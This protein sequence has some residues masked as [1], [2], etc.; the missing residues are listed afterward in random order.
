MFSPELLLVRPILA[1]VPGRLPLSILLALPDYVTHDTGTPLFNLPAAI[2]RL[3]GRAGYAR[4][5]KVLSPNIWAPG[6]SDAQL[7]QFATSPFH[8]RPEIF[9]EVHVAGLR[10]L[11][12]AG[13]GGLQRQYDIVHFIGYVTCMRDGSVRLVLSNE[14][15]GELGPGALRDSLVAAGTRLLI[16]QVPQSQF[17]RSRLL[18]EVVVNGGG[19]AVLM[20]T[21]R[22]SGIVDRYLLNLYANILHNIPIPL[23]QPES[24][25][26]HDWV[27]VQDVYAQQP[28]HAIS[29]RILYGTGGEN[30]LRFDAYVNEL[31]DRINRAQ[32]STQASASR[33]MTLAQT[34][35][36]YLH[37]SQVNA[38]MNLVETVPVLINSI[39]YQELKLNQVRWDRE[40]EGVIPIS[41]VAEN[42]AE[43][44][45]RQHT[46]LDK[47]QAV[48]NMELLPNARAHF[49]FALKGEAARGIFVQYGTDVD[50]IFNYG[51]P[52]ASAAVVR[53]S[54][55]ERV[56]ELQSP[57]G[58]MVA[59]IGLIFRGQSDSGYGQMHFYQDGTVDVV[60]FELRAMDEPRSDQPAGSSPSADDFIA[61]Y[62]TG[63]HIIF[64]LRGSLLYQFFLP[65]HLVRIL[66]ESEDGTPKPP[67]LTFDLDQ[68]KQFDDHAVE[69]QKRMAAAL[70]EVLS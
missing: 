11:S 63:F 64:D 18:A 16:L 28:E 20:V 36:S 66:P 61:P 67:P 46:L 44:E 35:Q 30:L 55:L 59:P 27:T 23:A 45:S 65:V 60:R 34:R 32:A 5:V 13:T 26:T 54:G 3:I 19:P 41:E 14:P 39:K 37:Q 56:R 33:L 68:L 9:K 53:A 43:V 7:L 42:L 57:L 17:E 62:T 29:I 38:L 49:Y 22:D 51:L 8:D 24:W 50:L 2:G 10:A 70:E 31:R 6:W 25:M 47:E 58:I 40:S 4:A 12:F 69:A 21:G 52:P 15:G 48:S 1:D